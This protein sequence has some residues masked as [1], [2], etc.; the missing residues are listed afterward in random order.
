MQCLPAEVDGIYLIR[1]IFISS[2][3]GMIWHDMWMYISPSPLYSTHNNT[4]KLRTHLTT[5]SQLTTSLITDQHAVFRL[6]YKHCGD[7]RQIST[8]RRRTATRPRQRVSRR[9]DSPSRPVT[10][11]PRRRLRACPASALSCLLSQLVHSTT[12][13]ATQRSMA[14]TRV[15]RRSHCTPSHIHLLSSLNLSSP[16]SR[17]SSSPSLHLLSRTLQSTH[18]HQEQPPIF[19]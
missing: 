1:V 7:Q 6:V 13:N 5:L 17:L 2:L 18:P 8:R 15:L 11:R 4:H 14:A 9:I 10:Q 16:H 19:W 12:T 3:D